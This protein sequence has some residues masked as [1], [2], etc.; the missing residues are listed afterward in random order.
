MLF[1][2]AGHQ[3]MRALEW[4]ELQRGM[5]WEESELCFGHCLD[6]LSTQMET[7]RQQ[8]NLRI[9]SLI[10]FFS[11][12]PLL[13]SFW[14]SSADIRLSNLICYFSY[15]LSSIS[16][17]FFL[18]PDFFWFFYGFCTFI[19][20]IFWIPRVLL[21]VLHCEVQC[22]H[23]CPQS[24]LPL[25]LPTR[26]LPWTTSHAHVITPKLF[27]VYGIPPIMQIASLGRAVGLE[28]LI[29]PS[30]PLGGNGL[31]K[32][33][34]AGS[35]SA[36]GQLGQALPGFWELEPHPERRGH[37]L[38][39][40]MSTW[41]LDSLT[42]WEWTWP[43]EGQGGVTQKIQSRPALGIL[44]HFLISLVSGTKERK[45]FSIP[46]SKKQTSTEILLVPI[47]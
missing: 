14:F 30:G 9:I 2:E 44:G 17:F 18:F 41:F 34:S 8:L 16:P 33:T 46:S 31:G 45:L 24:L 11:P 23:S 39:M 37:R 27:I 1:T 28:V 3:R 26:G 25:S 20:N 29:Q 40:G 38:Q 32:E 10:V 47:L 22:G 21:G 7:S 6:T 43:K 13:F 35:G 19:S 42:L 5:G 15:L 12:L 36:L 4:R